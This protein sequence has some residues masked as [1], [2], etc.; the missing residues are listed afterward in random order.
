MMTAQASGETNN[1]ASGVVPLAGAIYR[2]LANV[3]SRPEPQLESAVQRLCE[4][5]EQGDT[6]IQIADLN[7]DEAD[8]RAEAEMSERLLTCGV[9]GSPTQG[10]PLVLT[11]DHR[12]YFR[13]NWQTERHLAE[14]LVTR[15]RGSVAPPSPA[16]LSALENVFGL[17]DSP[18]KAAARLTATAPL[19]L[20][21]GGPG[22]GKTT[23]VLKLLACLHEAG[24]N[25]LEATALCAPGKAAARLR[26]A[27]GGTE[28]LP[29]A[30]KEALTKNV[31]TIHKLLQPL[32]EGGF[33]HGQGRP[34]P[35]RRLIV[36]EASMIDMVL[37]KHLLEALPEDACLLLLGDPDQLASVEAGA[38]FGD[39]TRMRLA[40]EEESRIDDL[41]T[42]KAA[43]ERQTIRYT[44]NFRFVQQPG[45]STLCEC[46]RNGDTS[47]ALELLA[48]EG[49][50]EVILNELSQPEP[51]KDRAL[52]SA[53]QESLQ[54]LLE[55]MEVETALNRLDAQR[56]LCVLRQGPFGVA[57]LTR[58]LFRQQGIDEQAPHSWPNGMPILLTRNAP[59]LGLANGDVGVLWRMRGFAQVHFS[60]DIVVP[61]SALPAWEAGPVL[62]VHR[63]QGSEYSCVHLVLPP[64]DHPLLTRELIY[65][66]VSRARER[67]VIWG[68]GEVLAKAIA[69]RTRRK[70]GLLEQLADCW[71]S[72]KLSF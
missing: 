58:K 6:C 68:C 27:I 4:A 62:T 13:R 57:G 46:V 71:K 26:E 29:E 14:A 12:L 28:R 1:T 64:E 34:L 33:R 15:L 23:G 49:S 25:S 17:E 70:T 39:L 43:M 24:E 5:L 2:F 32:P 7:A 31:S 50:N 35:L 41:D 53:L 38:V 20:I 8:S 69:Q 45:I 21:C 59:R 36:D 63:S 40:S 56:V 51:M 22:T 11:R 60:R 37:L 18:A 16:F 65:T 55:A 61:L 52:R 42:F 30:L 67:V 66:A 44:Q 10:R 9:A 72:P 48:S 3:A 47:A 19:T 54:P